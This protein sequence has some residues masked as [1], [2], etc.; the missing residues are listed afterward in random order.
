MNERAA[1]ALG[2][3]LGDRA[4]TIRAAL[5]LLAPE[6]IQVERVSELV[7][8]RAIG[9]GEQPDYLN[10]AATLRTALSPRQLLDALLNIE[11]ELGRV[12][13]ERTR[14]T[15]RTIDL[16][17]L[18]YADR[19]LTEPGLVVPHPRMLERAFVLVPLAMIA[20]EWIVPGTG[21][22]VAVHAARL[23]ASTDHGAPLQTDWS[24]H[25]LGEPNHGGKQT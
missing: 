17:L 23:A 18:L 13:D 7:V 9:P 11:R 24:Q 2:A 15:P 10:A 16:D 1:I 20:P 19:L 4:G 12:R 25:A 8:T 21:Q 22:S 3:N 6:G 5:D 14:W